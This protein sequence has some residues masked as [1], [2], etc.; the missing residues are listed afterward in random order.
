[1]SV[2]VACLDV[3]VV[4][5]SVVVS[6]VFSVVVSSGSV[7]ASSVVSLLGSSEIA[8]DSLLGAPAIVTDLFPRFPYQRA[9]QRCNHDKDKNKTFQIDESD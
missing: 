7:V 8:D 4:V 5:R 3:V 9:N 2:P 6:S 1:M